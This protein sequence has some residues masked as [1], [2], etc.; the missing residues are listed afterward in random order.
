MFRRRL[1]KKHDAQKKGRYQSTKTERRV[2]PEQSYACHFGK[3][4][5]NAP[6]PNPD[7]HT[8]HPPSIA[9][10]H[11]A[12][13]RIL[14]RPTPTPRATRWGGTFRYGHP[15]PSLPASCRPAAASMPQGRPF[16][17]PLTTATRQG[18]A[19][20]SPR[21][22]ATGRPS[23]RRLARLLSA[24]GIVP[25]TFC[26]HRAGMLSLQLRPTGPPLSALAIASLG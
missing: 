23:V 9:C 6:N 12:R 8:S 22:R 17:R 13:S 5:G 21:L 20:P 26:R 14:C 3:A 11:R 10:G 2:D 7:A 4:Q 24:P 15:W 19:L 16:A 18:L 1:K 25:R